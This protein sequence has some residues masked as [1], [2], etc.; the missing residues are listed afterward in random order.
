MQRVYVIS[1]VV[2]EGREDEI[3]ATL[4]SRCKQLITTAFEELIDEG[5]LDVQDTETV[6]E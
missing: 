4:V 1:L 2:T 6:R 3:P 5:I